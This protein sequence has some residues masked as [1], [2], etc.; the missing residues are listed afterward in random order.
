MKE[1]FRCYAEGLRFNGYSV[2]YLMVPFSAFGK[3]P[4]PVPAAPPAYTM[5][6]TCVVLRE[7][8]R[9]FESQSTIVED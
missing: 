5:L 1:A 7:K 6:S 3:N 9:L 2:G 4:P 8:A